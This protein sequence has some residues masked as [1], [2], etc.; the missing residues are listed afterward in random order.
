MSVY[1]LLLDFSVDP[2][3][4]KN[5][6]HLSLLSSNIEN[7]LR[8]YI[9]NLKLI[10]TL[11]VAGG[12]LNMYS[13]DM[14]SIITLRI[15]SNGTI[16]LNIEYLKGD[17][18]DY[19]LTLEKYRE[20]ERNLR[21]CGI[22]N[23]TRYPSIHRG[24]FSRYFV[25]SDDRLLEYD[26]DSILFEE[27]SRF[28][29]VQVVHSKSLGNMLVLDD[30]QNISEADLI[31][32]ETLM[33]RGKENYKDKEIVILGGGDGALLYELLKEQPKHVT[34]LEIDEVVMRACNQ[35]MR[36]ICGDVLDRKSTINY[37]IIVGDCMKSLDQFVMEERKFDYVFGDLTDVPI[38]DDSESEIWNFVK[39]Y[40]SLSFKIL[41]PTGKFMSHGNGACCSLALEKYESYLATIN[42][43]LVINKCQAFIPSFME[44]WVFY[45]IHFANQG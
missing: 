15:F 29:K 13:G 4:V 30:L 39:K 43:P 12:S 27:R 2:K 45:Q 7:I 11:S 33:L 21:G 31:Y 14:G 23:D 28:Q 8:D 41:K 6:S 1:T 24:T 17:D 37:Q 32:T 20:M 5:E 10:T 44:F 19:I 36:S 3:N 35:H 34:M 16:T 25:S 40:L 9:R 42:P 26:I 38:A 22:L 18:Q